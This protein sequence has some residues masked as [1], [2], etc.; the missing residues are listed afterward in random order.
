MCDPI[1]ASVLIGSAFLTN[2]QGNKAEDAQQ[3]AMAA[4]Q[5]E[6]DETKK[7]AEE[8]KIKSRRT[9]K[10]NDPRA[11]AR[12]RNPSDLFAPTP[13]SSATESPG[14][15]GRGG[16]SPDVPTLGAPSG[17]TYDTFFQPGVY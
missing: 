8:A 9:L 1:S 11:K 16:S 4:N 3:N 17:S 6:A 10:F 5:R 13:G 14:S 15:V 7:L 12:V 2:A